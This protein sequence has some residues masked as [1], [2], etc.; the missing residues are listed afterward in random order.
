M[1]CG[2]HVADVS[3]N[4]SPTRPKM[5]SKRAPKNVLPTGHC[6]HIANMSV[7]LL[8]FIVLFGKL[9]GIF[10][11]LTLILNNHSIII[12]VLCRRCSFRCRRRCCRRCSH[13]LS[14]CRV[15]AFLI[16]ITLTST[17]TSSYLSLIVLIPCP[18]PCP[19]L[20]LLL[21]ML[22]LLSTSLTLSLLS[23]S[24]LSSSSYHLNL[25]IVVLHCPCP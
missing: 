17:S 9:T 14:C 19:A 2:Q 1:I 20:S 11:H 12:L 5:M 18:C 24:L 16:L 22:S 3:A 6:R 23:L 7:L 4:M 21:S 8:C 13:S 15:I 10:I 25:I